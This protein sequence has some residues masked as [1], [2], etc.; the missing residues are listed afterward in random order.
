M[1]SLPPAGDVFAQHDAF[2]STYTTHS[3]HVDDNVP[4][5]TLPGLVERHPVQTPP[6]DEPAYA[7]MNNLV[8]GALAPIPS[9]PAPRHPSKAGPDLRL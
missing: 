9:P 6:A 5:A 4:L 7:N 1:G 2:D 8:G 3:R